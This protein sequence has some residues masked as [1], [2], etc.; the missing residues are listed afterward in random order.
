MENRIDQALRGAQG[1]QLM[2][3]VVAGYPDL[4]TNADLIRLMAKR[5]VKLME[6]QIPFTDPLADGPTIMRANQAALDAGITPRHCFELCAALSKELPDVAFMF[7]TYGNIPF[8]MGMEN[9]LDRTAA[10]GASGVILPDLPW[11]ETDGDYAE[12]ARKRGLHPV[13]VI[14]PDTEGPRLDTILSRAS[15]LLYT[16]LKVGITGAGASMD[17]TGVDYVRNLKNKAGLPIAAGFGI[18]KPEHVAMLDGLA[19]AAVVGSHII[20]LLDA[21]GLRAV[22]AFLAACRG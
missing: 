10:S 22:D 11:D 18:S 15:G 16:T 12:A 4:D 14:S 3:H 6:I 21:G 2:T 20:N 7:M 8:A 5:G 19:D 9:F 1:I 17:Q 13:M